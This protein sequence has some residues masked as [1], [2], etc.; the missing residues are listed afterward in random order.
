[1]K[2]I[3][4]ALLASLMLLPVS[5]CTENPVEEYGTGLTDAYIDSKDA[6]KKADLD[7]AKRGITSFRA[8]EGR[9]P[10]SLDEIST[11]M[12]MRLSAEDYDY[13]PSTG[14]ISLR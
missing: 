2:L 7:I 4:I 1:M 11:Y 6:A 9:Y 12:S 8:V 5:G 3:I 10:R 14:R 13:D